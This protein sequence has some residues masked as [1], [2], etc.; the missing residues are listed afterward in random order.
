M[1]QVTVFLCAILALLSVV[2]SAPTA[3]A[4]DPVP[5][6]PNGKYHIYNGNRHNPRGFLYV[7]GSPNKNNYA[8]TY[9]LASNSSNVLQ[10]WKL[11]N[12]SSGAISLELVGKKGYYL[13]THRSGANPGAHLATQ[14]TTQ[15]KWKIKKVLGG[16]FT[17]Y[18]LTYPHKVR[19]QTLAVDH[20]DY[21]DAM[22]YVNLNVLDPETTQAFKFALDPKA[23]P[24]DPAGAAAPL[25]ANGNYRIHNGNVQVPLT[26]RFFT[27]NPNPSLCDITLQPKSAI[28]GS[29]QIWKLRNHSSGTIS[30]ELVGKPGYYLGEGRSSGLP[31]AYAGTTN[32]NRQKWKI[33]RVAVD[34]PKQFQGKNLVLIETPDD[35][36][37]KR[38]AFAYENLEQM[39]AWRFA[40]A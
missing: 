30:L 1:R 16:E 17:K 9:Q 34:F 2:L 21:E 28:P 5:L 20:T 23:A 4:P 24:V 15:Q 11:R 38:V 37:P 7:S 19:N 13:G 29:H 35:V 6:R 32:A 12:H 31:G 14:K 39:Q 22:N 27:G 10:V 18:Q 26:Y 40:P 25:L 3:S 8:V 33:T 36:N